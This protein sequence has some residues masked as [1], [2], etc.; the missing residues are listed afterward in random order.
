[1]S[2][3]AN[4]PYVTLT[5]LDHRPMSIKDW[6]RLLPAFL[7]SCLFN[8]GFIYVLIH[9]NS[10]QARADANIQSTKDEQ[11]KLE[12]KNKA[13]EENAIDMKQSQEDLKEKTPDAD[14]PP[15]PSIDIPEEKPIGL[16]LETPPDKPIL[17]GAGPGEDG[18]LR[19]ADEKLNSAEGIKGDPILGEMMGAAG[20]TGALPTGSGVGLLTGGN[21]GNKD[22]GGYG[23]RSGDL[24]AVAKLMGGSDETQ[25]AVGAG[26]TWLRM[27]Q[28]TDGRWSYDKYH[29]YDAKCDCRTEQ[30]KSFRVVNGVN[31]PNLRNDDSSA[32]ALGVLPF[33]GA[34]HHHKKQT[35]EGRIVGNALKFLLPRIGSDGSVLKS[36]GDM[37]SQGIVSIALCEAYGLTQDPVLGTAAQNTINFIVRSQ[38]SQTGGWR[39]QPNTNGDTSVVGWQV[40]ALKSAVMAGL[41]VPQSSLDNTSRWLESAQLKRMVDGKPRVQFAYV[42]RDEG[43]DKGGF[44]T[45]GAS[46]AGLLG[47]LYLGWGPRNPDL[48]AGCENLMDYAPPQDAKPGDMGNIYVWY[49]AAQVMHHVGGDYWDRWNPRMRDYLVKSQH[50]QGHRHGSWDPSNDFVGQVGGRLYS[51]SLSILTLEVYYRFLPLYRRE[52][53]AAKDEVVSG[54]PAEKAPEPKMPDKK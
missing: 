53:V 29:T 45:P 46:A 9:F 3:P 28:S 11:T 4:S 27:H 13:E 2:K 54:K 36:G 47:R 20:T 1:M 18:K 39:Y 15:L 35:D 26:L 41:K 24:S 32:T 31:V 51:T 34:G 21:R 16:N 17:S 30:E 5:E 49:Y 33:L 50:K 48:L 43:E 22:S 19:G 14:K 52:K 23:V 38:N 40:M 25:R 10:P 12:E 44:P 8:A 42:I 37:Y 7:L 6:L